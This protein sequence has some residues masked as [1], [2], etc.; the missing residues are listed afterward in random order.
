MAH[1][2]FVYGSTQIAQFQT[3]WV[4]WVGTNGIR[5]GKW[6]EGVLFNDTDGQADDLFPGGTRPTHLS[7]S[8]SRMPFMRSPSRPP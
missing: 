3:R 8:L 7:F 2:P 4:C 1:G 5:F 6:T